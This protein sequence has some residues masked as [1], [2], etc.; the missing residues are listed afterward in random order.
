MHASAAE[1]TVNFGHDEPHTGDSQ[2]ETKVTKGNCKLQWKVDWAMRWIAL[3]V[4]YEMC[5]K[6]LTESAD[7]ASKICKSI[8][9]KPP[10]NLNV[11]YHLL[12]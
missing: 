6:D 5:G 4:D 1:N 2:V 11:S 8:S 9:K 7:L 10:V 12:S 3:G